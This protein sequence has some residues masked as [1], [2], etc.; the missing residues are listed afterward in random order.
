MRGFS[1][2]IICDTARKFVMGQVAGQNLSFSP[3]VA[4]FVSAAQHLADLRKAQT[5]ALPRGEVIHSEA[6]DRK[7][8]RVRC[9]YAGRELIASGINIE[10]FKEMA[11]KKE[12]P[13]RCEYVGLLGEIYAEKKHA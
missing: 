4:E 1:D 9:S 13:D 12:L 7:V 2:Q 3:S 8:E 11:G 6:I 10:K 5:L